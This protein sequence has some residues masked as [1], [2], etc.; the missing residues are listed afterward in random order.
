MA[1]V[2][3]VTKC[4]YSRKLEAPQPRTGKMFRPEAEENTIWKATITIRKLM[5]MPMTANPMI[6]LSG[7]RLR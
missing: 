4:R 7:Q 3:T 2:G 1:S 6:A 5:L